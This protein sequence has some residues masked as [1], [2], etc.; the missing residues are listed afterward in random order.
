MEVKKRNNPIV[1]TTNC[2]YDEKYDTGFANF[3]DE[4]I[5]DWFNKNFFNQMETT[6]VATFYTIDG[7]KIDLTKVKNSRK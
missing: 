1:Y 6:D 2:A 3:I 4:Q 7:E 5:V